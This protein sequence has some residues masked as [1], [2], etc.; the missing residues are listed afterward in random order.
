MNNDIFDEIT[1]FGVIPVIA[2][3][4]VDDALP[5]ADALLEGGLPVVEITFRTDAA[6]DVIQRL[7]EERK[8][9]LIG[10]GTIL[11]PENAEKAKRLGATFAVAPGL[12]PAVVKKAQEVDLPFAPGFATATDIEN[13]LALGCWTLKFFPSEALGGIKMLKALSGPYGH[14]G[15]RFVP[16]GGVKADNLADYITTP[17][18]VAVGGTWLATK[19]DIAEGRWKEISKRAAEA[20]EIVEH[21]RG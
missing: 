18:V 2:I 20:V 15:V 5:L 12:N 4:S 10:A 19:A 16:T 7:S 6:P 21:A 11:T 3:D 17:S 8:E 14:T 13:A 1:R 9:L